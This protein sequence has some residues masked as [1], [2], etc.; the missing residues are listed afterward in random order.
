MLARE[1]NTPLP[2]LMQMTLVEAAEWSAAIR[3]AEAR[4]PGNA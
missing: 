2:M 3:R 4:E 1:L